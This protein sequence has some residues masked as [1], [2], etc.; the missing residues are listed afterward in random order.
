M[1]NKRHN[2]TDE[3]RDE[4]ISLLSECTTKDQCDHII[5]ITEKFRCLMEKD[6]ES[7]RLYRNKYGYEGTLDDELLDFYPED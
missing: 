2:Q 4:F 5:A 7:Q 3:D 1:S 6:E